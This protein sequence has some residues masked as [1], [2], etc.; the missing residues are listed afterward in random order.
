MRYLKAVLL[1][2][3]RLL[4]IE[5]AGDT[6]VVGVEEQLSNSIFQCRWQQVAAWSALPVAKSVKA[7]IVVVPF[8]P[9]KE[10]IMLWG[11]LP[12]TMTSSNHLLGYSLRTRRYENVTGNMW[13]LPGD[14]KRQNRAYCSDLSKKVSREHNTKGLD[15]YKSNSTIVKSSTF[16]VAQM[17]DAI[18][19]D[20]G[21]VALNCGEKGIGIG[22]YQP[23]ASCE[24][25]YR[26]IGKR[27]ISTCHRNLTR[28]GVSFRELI[29]DTERHGATCFP[30][31]VL[32]PGWPNK[33][34][35]KD[36][37]GKILP[38]R[39]R[40]TRGV[41][42]IKYNKVFMATAGWDHNYHHFIIDSLTRIVRHLDWLK[43]NP[44][45]KIHLRCYEST[46]L[47]NEKMISGGRL[48]RSKFWELLG[49]DQARLIM[50]PAAASTVWVPRESKCNDP[51]Q[52]AYEVR[53]LSRV[54]KNAAQDR[55]DRARASGKIPSSTKSN[56]RRLVASGSGGGGGDGGKPSMRRRRK[57]ARL[58]ANKR[59][60]RKKYASEDDY[61]DDDGSELHL[62]SR[63][64]G[65][66]SRQKVDFGGVDAE[67]EVRGDPD[68]QVEEVPDVLLQA[69]ASSQ[70]IILVQQ[71]NCETRED[72]E[73]TW[74]EWNNTVASSVV[75]SFQAAFPD[76]LVLKASDNDIALKRCVWCQISL[77]QRASILVGIHGAGL[78]N[79]MFMAPGTV[80]VELTGEFDGR[81]APVC[82]YHGPLAAAFGVHHYLW[83]WV[84]KVSMKHPAMYPRLDEIAALGREV[85]EFVGSL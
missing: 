22:Y 45:V 34:K 1:L 20:Q 14:H 9:K 2:F 40:I 6:E 72:C 75:S 27:F 83:L 37:A 30:Q 16:Y 59:Q 54:M 56:K 11:S 62:L 28:H 55:L 10:E 41:R 64:Q 12:G 78:T 84:W 19:Q 35:K 43:A 77:Y 58:K 18:I 50:G 51:L 57:Q 38:P 68:S 53:L 5:S 52:M 7:P 82:G 67:T 3:A 80:L 66:A 79:I 44:D 81:M 31:E 85:K 23:V 26:F 42:L 15:L 71:R 24:T 61:I 63:R 33:R 29:D 74:R 36:K 47:R 69:L 49:I 73:K 17:H 8:P 21:L 76:H 25:F 48:L 70:P 32:D 65:G 13:Q 60:S 39:P 46:I 4:E